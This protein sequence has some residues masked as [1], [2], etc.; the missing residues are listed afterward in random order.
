M[1]YLPADISYGIQCATEGCDITPDVAQFFYD[2]NDRN[3]SAEH[4][5]LD[6]AEINWEACHRRYADLYTR[7]YEEWFYDRATE[8]QQIW[9]LLASAD[10]YAGRVGEQIDFLYRRYVSKCLA[11]GT[12]FTDENAMVAYLQ[13]E[14]VWTHVVRNTTSMVNR[15]NVVNA[16]NL[17]VAFTN[18]GAIYTDAQINSIQTA[19]TTQLTIAQ[20][21]I[22]ENFERTQSPSAAAQWEKSRRKKLKESRKVLKK[23]SSFVSR[24]LGRQ[25]ATAFIRGNE[26]RV[27]GR[28][29]DFLLKK[30]NLLTT[31]HGGFRISVYARDTG[32]RMVDLCWYV[33]ETPALDQLAALV[34]AVKAGEED[35]II[36]I[37]NHLA[38]SQD[39]VEHPEFSKCLP[40]RGNYI[41]GDF[42]IEGN[43]LT[44]GGMGDED[45][46]MNYT[47]GT[48][49]NIN[50]NAAAYIQFVECANASL[51]IINTIAQPELFRLRAANQVREIVD[52]SV[53]RII[54][55]NWDEVTYTDDQVET[56]VNEAVGLLQAAADTRLERL[57]AA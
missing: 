28:R 29:Y 20:N 8:P 44:V 27:E 34:M 47:P 33:P 37:G 6:N 12:P 5:A 46:M 52:N 41:N 21:Q 11:D 25:D 40:D 18:R 1:R 3:I 42:V 48:V 36:E 54:P 10:R 19:Y 22:V 17:Q 56:A 15:I 32:K 51:N 57:I 38:I 55:E 30:S 24:L 43:L 35:D 16:N 13:E 4:D 39:A 7:V 49:L 9:C 23:S 2:F 31:G 50:T 45:R 14:E 53:G 26:I